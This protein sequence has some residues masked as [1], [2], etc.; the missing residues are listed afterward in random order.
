MTNTQDAQQRVADFYDDEANAY[1]ARFDSAAG[2]YIHERQVSIIRDLL[3]DVTGKTVL[4]IAAGTGRFT[5]VLRADGAE[6]VV[7]DIAREMLE[8]NRKR[9][10]SATFIHGTASELPLQRDSVDACV[11]VNALNH[12]P[13]HWDVVADVHRVLKS[14]GPLVANY[15]NVLSNRFP[16][17]AYVNYRNR[18]IGGGVYTEWFNVFRVKKR[19]RKLGYDVDACVGDRLVPV[20]AASRVTVPVARAMERFVESGPLSNL[21]VSPFVKASKQ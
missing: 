11:T 15:P 9:T 4:E 2:R 20:K 21:C 10:P 8:R 18:N 13:G 3:G 17:A 5:E 6:V 1:D 19:L 12:I 7:V 16:I 14:G